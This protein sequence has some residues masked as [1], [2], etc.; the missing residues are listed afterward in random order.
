MVGIG[1]AKTEQGLLPLQP[2]RL[3]VVLQLVPFIAGDHGVYLV[4]PF[5]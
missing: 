1:P 4:F 5:N 2:G 3:K